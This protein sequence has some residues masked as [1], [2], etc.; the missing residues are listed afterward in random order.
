MDLTI[1][2]RP[3]TGVQM[4]VPRFTG[5]GRFGNNF[6]LPRLGS[7]TTAELVFGYFNIGFKTK[8]SSN[9]PSGWELC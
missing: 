2:P 9:D 8:Y 4:I 7:Y 3:I 6:I 1:D 5:Q